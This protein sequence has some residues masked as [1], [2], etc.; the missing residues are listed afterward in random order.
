MPGT[1]SYVGLNTDGAGK[2]VATEEY[3]RSDG[4]VVEVQQIAAVD[5]K[6]GRS[7]DAPPWDDLKTL[8]RAIL[9]EMRVL[10]AMFAE[11]SQTTD[12]DHLRAAYHEEPM[13]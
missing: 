13:P 5:P 4:A 3:T 1:D 6:T 9:V 12:A 2:K 11:E 7:L 10:V 8:L